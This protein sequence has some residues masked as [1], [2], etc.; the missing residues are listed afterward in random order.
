MIEIFGNS[1]K[2]R[3]AVAKGYTEIPLTGGRYI[4]DFSFPSSKLRR[5]RVQ[6]TP[7]Y[8]MSGIDLWWK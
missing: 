8:D 1:I 5:G 6:G 3:Q 7:Q 2:I 4:A